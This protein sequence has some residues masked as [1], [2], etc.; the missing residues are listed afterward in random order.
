[1]EKK[2]ADIIITEYLQ[3]IYGFAYKKSFSYDEA[4]ELASEMTSEVYKSLLAAE[5]IYNIEGYVWRICEHTYARYV[6]SVKRNEGVS[7]DSVGDIAYHERFDTGETDEELIRLRREIA[8]L[9]A[10]RRDIVFRFYYKNEPIREIASR[11]DL[12]EGT[13]KWHLNK[14][15]NELKEGLKMERKI[16]SLGINPVK[17]CEIGHDGNP[18]G[19]NRDASYYLSDKLNLNI[20]Y[21]CYTEPRN[22]NEIA[23]ELGVTPVFIEDKVNFLES[24]GFLVRTKG[25][26]FTTYVCF[27]PRTYSREQLDQQRGRK[28]KVAEKLVKEY[29]PA[30]IKAAESVKDVYVP[31]G[32]RQLFVSAAVMYALMYKC[33]GK[34]K[35]PDRSKYF[36]KTTD[37]GNY[38]ASV[39]LEC[40]CTDPE[41]K[42]KNNGSYVSCGGMWRGPGKYGV[43][44]WSLDTRYDSR[45]GG[46]E[47][48]LYT[49]YEYLYEYMTGKL[50]DKKVNEEKFARLAER[51]YVGKDGGINVTI[52]KGTESAFRDA[53]P[54]PEAGLLD[55]AASLALESAVVEAKRYPPQMQDLIVSYNS[56]PVDTVC[57]L[58]A[59]DILYADGTFKPLTEKE[60]VAANLI[61]FSD[62]LPE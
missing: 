50:T 13:V 34:N 20:V 21:A 11:L 22:L 57:A 32:N 2:K 30:V 60:K 3:K 53:L 28:Q 10:S 56:V 23:E 44:S 45:K 17:A 27:G 33:T 37:G 36:I 31:G 18:G 52:F 49:D 19:N 7:I 24:N 25:D 43:T 39:S 4:E 59:L 46:W 47:N 38:I 12:P 48:N 35:G 61:M 16:G 62:V 6:A 26:R 8:F 1:M 14:A 55:E 54:S 40:E 15:R 41:Y 5:D 58:M 51:G 42:M 9:S 29:V